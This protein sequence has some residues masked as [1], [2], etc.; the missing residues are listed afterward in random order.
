MSDLARGLLFL[1][2]C[3]FTQNAVF[4]RMLAPGVFFR[5]D[6]VKTAA[7]FAAAVTVVMTL[8]ALCGWILS[9]AVLKPLHAEYLQTLAFAV[10]AALLTWIV[11]TVVSKARLAWSEHLSDVVGL[12]MAGQAVLAVAVLNMEKG[13]GL[14]QAVMN[15]LFSGLGFLLALVC[16]AGVQE[17]LKTSKIPGSFKGLPIS[18]VSAGLI[19]L[20]F[21]GVAGL[22]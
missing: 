18:L 6:G 16:M 22:G 5:K 13:Y 12:L 10:T 21:M 9:H 19:A 17:R 3:V 20:A 15:G 7:V 4:D 11:T 8:T 14:A 2:S 1:V